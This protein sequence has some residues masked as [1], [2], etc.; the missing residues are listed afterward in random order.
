MDGHPPL[1]RH[2]LSGGCDRGADARPYACAGGRDYQRDH[3]RADLV[4]HQRV[5]L[6][7]GLPDV[8]LAH[9]GPDSVGLRRAGGAGR[10][11]GCGDRAAVQAGAGSRSGGA[12]RGSGAR[13]RAG[14]RAC[15]AP[16]LP[17]H[18]LG[19]GRRGGRQRPD[20]LCRDGCAPRGAHGAGRRSP[21]PLAGGRLVRRRVPDGRRHGRPQPAGSHG[22]AGGGDHGVVRG[23]VFH[24]PADPTP[25]R[26]DAVTPMGHCYQLI[27]V[28]FRYA[29]DW[30]LRDFSLE[31]AEGEFLGLIGPNGAGKSSLLKL[32]AGLLRPNQGAVWLHGETLESL[33][34]R[35]IARHVAVVPQESQVLFPFTVAELV[36]MGRFTHQEGWGWDSP[37]DL[38]IARHAMQAMDILQVATRTFRELSGGERQ[39]A[40]IA[41]ALAQ[42]AGILLLDEPTAFLDINH[43]LDIYALLQD[44]NRNRGVT[45]VAV[46]HYLNIPSQHGD[47]LVMAHQGRVYQSGAPEQVV[48]PEHIRTVYGCDVIID[49][50][51]EAGTPRVTLPQVGP[52]ASSNV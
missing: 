25:R 21:A 27:D 4:H 52:R 40:I 38:Q 48:T 28:S 8:L 43:Q 22:I 23:A 17:D 30:V 45:V 24:L 34:P 31:V 18:G 36:L 2:H 35:Q 46:S 16:D 47:R 50:H 19:N 20:R 44:L 13:V 3:L 5:R 41:R 26:A 37:A 14:G 12:G 11:A 9:G 1:D 42:Q 10:V 7:E 49:R 33:S 51:P 29:R 15:E 6:D 39:R 32:T